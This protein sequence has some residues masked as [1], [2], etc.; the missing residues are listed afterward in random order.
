MTFS[1]TKV[2]QLFSQQYQNNHLFNVFSNIIIHK[3]CACVY[4]Y[5]N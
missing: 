5:W 4:L 1:M 2:K 3:M